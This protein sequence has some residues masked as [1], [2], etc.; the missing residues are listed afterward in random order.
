MFYH[1]YGSGKIKRYNDALLN[2]YN[3]QETSQN[4]IFLF[5]LE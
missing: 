3:E 2:N 5:K 1:D 4:S